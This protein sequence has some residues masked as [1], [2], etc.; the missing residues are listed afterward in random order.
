MVALVATAQIV[1]QRRKALMG[2]SEGQNAIESMGTVAVSV[3]A[4]L[5]LAMRMDWVLGRC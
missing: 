1:T 5:K 3:D 2:R 4:R